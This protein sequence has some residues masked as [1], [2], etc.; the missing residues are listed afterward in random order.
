[1]KQFIFV[2]HQSVA[3]F[4]KDVESFMALRTVSI[5]QRYQS[6]SVWSKRVIRD[7]GTAFDWV[8]ARNKNDVGRFA[9]R[10]RGGPRIARQPR[11]RIARQLRPQSPS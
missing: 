2:P 7:D 6:K 11:T 9:A 8:R 4:V 3:G 5:G 10:T 1:M